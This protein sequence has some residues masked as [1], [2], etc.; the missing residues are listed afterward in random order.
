[1]SLTA[2][3]IQEVC[4]AVFG[5]HEWYWFESPVLMTF[6]EATYEH[7][8]DTYLRQCKRCNVQQFFEVPR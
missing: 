5:S 2:E 8:F 4:P 1:M 6:N 3:E 7:L